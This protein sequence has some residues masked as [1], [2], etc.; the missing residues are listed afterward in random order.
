MLER[1]AQAGK[2]CAG[3]GLP[4]PLRRP[5]EP[6]SRGMGEGASLMPSV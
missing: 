5:G 3:L 2:L 1:W 4:W 6:A